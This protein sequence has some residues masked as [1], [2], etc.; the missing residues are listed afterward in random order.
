MLCDLPSVSLLP[1]KEMGRQA[2]NEKEPRV[3]L[4]FVAP[5]PGWKPQRALDAAPDPELL[6]FAPFGRATEEPVWKPC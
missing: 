2:D 3:E 5:P 6:H 4:H 1:L